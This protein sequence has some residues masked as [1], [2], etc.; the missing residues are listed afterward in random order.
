MS[1]SFQWTQDEN[2]H[3]SLRTLLSFMAARDI[4]D[5]DKSAEK[6]ERSLKNGFEEL[7]KRNFT[8]GV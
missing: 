7:K 6:V 5:T 2:L 4:G 1:R 3:Q 8:L